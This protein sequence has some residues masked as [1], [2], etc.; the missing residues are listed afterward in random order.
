MNCKPGDL[1]IVVKACIVENIGKI[2]EVIGPSDDHPV[3]GFR[4]SIR[5]QSPMRSVDG[6]DLTTQVGPSL[7]NL[8]CADDWLRPVSGLPITD[9]VTDDLK[10]PA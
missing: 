4:W 7:G 10:E 2:V 6:I 1:A 5:P 8:A 3:L 9:E